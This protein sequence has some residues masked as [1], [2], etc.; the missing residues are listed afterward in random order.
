MKMHIMILMTGFVLFSI[1]GS[2]FA[3]EFG[4]NSAILNNQ[5]FPVKFDDR[6]I[7]FGYGDWEGNTTYWDV[8]GIEVV[9]T[10]RCLKVNRIS[11]EE[12]SFTTVWFAQDTEGNVWALKIY[13]HHV[14]KTFYLGD[15]IKSWFMPASP[16]VGL[17][18][19]LIVPE[20]DQTYSKIMATGVTVPELSTGIGPFVDCLKVNYWWEGSPNGAV[21][22]FC[23]N[24]GCVRNTD[25]F[26][27]NKGMDLK[28]VISAGCLCDVN[29]DG[30]VGLEDTIYILQV[31][32][33]LRP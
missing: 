5:Y 10:V 23:P 21:E 31:L 14:D 9:N 17:N 30:K 4:T 13:M 22:Y 27:N 8:V 32:S 26:E 25:D 11:T 33:G 18:A 20:S 28:E 19:G 16:A 15:G 2:A 24:V 7:D 1:G 12:S 29:C 3:A 6:R